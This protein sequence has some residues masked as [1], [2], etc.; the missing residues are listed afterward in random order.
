MEDNEYEKWINSFHNF[1]KPGEGKLYIIR[2]S[3][4]L[5]QVY[6]DLEKMGV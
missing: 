4:D 5:E 1:V 6:R 3:D 2:D